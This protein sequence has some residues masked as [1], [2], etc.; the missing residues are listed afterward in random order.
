M[1]ASKIDKPDAVNNDPARAFRRGKAMN[2][3][4]R[5]G[6]SRLLPAILLPVGIVMGVGAQ[7]AVAGAAP[8][9]NATA[10]AHV[11]S[12]ASDHDGGSSCAVLS[13]GRVSCW[14]YND[15]GQLGNGTTTS[16]DAPVTAIG[17]RGATAIA[18]SQSGHSFC[19]LLSTGHLEC[20]GAN[21]NGQLG[22]GTTTN[23]TVPVAVKNIATAT[24]IV[25]GDYGFCAILSSTGL[26]CWGYNGYGQLGNGTFTSSDVPVA[27][28][29]TT[30][31]ARLISGDDDYCALLASD[32]VSC[33]G[34]GGNGELGNGTTTNS[35]VPVTV[36]GMTTAT[37]VASDDDGG[38]YCAVLSSGH[39]NCWGYNDS[40][41]LGNGTTTSSN[42]PV[43]AI[44][45]SKG[46]GMAG[47]PDGNSFCAVLSTGHL[48]CWGANG[49]GQLGN[50]T[51]T[52]YTLPVL[53]KNIT[54]AA[55]VIGGDYGFCARL[56]TN[57]L[58]CWGYNA[59]GEL[60]N[61]TTTSSDVPVAVEKI[62]D[63]AQTMS[64][65]YGYCSLLTTDHVDCWG[66][67][68]N[69]ELGDGNTT[70]SDVPLPVI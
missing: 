48:D 49:Y 27:V 14:G 40:G 6:R 1:F 32:H 46:V 22:N 66:Y 69:G 65:D 33:W 47:S 24:A 7:T 12:I 51:A 25:G 61:G 41:Q 15:A 35:D 60:G 64:G 10:L 57:H 2:T 70:N 4:V 3:A 16:S 52:N 67:N 20:W 31:V 42:V 9:V 18:G 50:G 68:G 54:K 30:N 59:Y 19:A 44:G 26:D 11:V 23:F 58:S 8:A 34:F 53:V 43:A 29:G 45:I 39:V 38:S 21:S 17:V 5:P 63:A 55:A 36:S 56:S 62:R 37:T 13:T 28:Q